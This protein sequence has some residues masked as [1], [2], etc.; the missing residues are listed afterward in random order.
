MVAKM[1]ENGIDPTPGRGPI[2]RAQTSGHGGLLWTFG[3]DK[4]GPYPASGAKNETPL[5]I[6]HLR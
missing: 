6:R 4:S 2:Y 3:R 1:F 5:F